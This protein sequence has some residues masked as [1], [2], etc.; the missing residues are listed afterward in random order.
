MGMDD[1]IRWQQRFEAWFSTQ[2]DDG[3]GAHSVAH[4]RRVWGGAQKIMAQEQAEPLVVLAACYFHDIVNLPKNHPERHLA[5]GK[6]AV[7]TR[8]ILNEDFPDFP[9]E[10][11]D[12]VAHAV[13]AHSFSAGITPLT[14]EAKVVQDADRLES[15]GAIGLARVFYVSGLLGRELF[16]SDDPLAERRPL[17]DARYAVDHFRQKLLKLPQTM[18]TRMGQELAYRNADFLVEYL[19]KLCAELNGDYHD[20][21]TSV[22][23]RLM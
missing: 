12:A 19:A 22:R 13:H 23:R 2:P 10:L 15:L 20:A 8:Q 14:I 5:S 1:T 3:D 16:D 7:R 4:F 6:A 18:Q 17:D 11:H 9:L 21:D